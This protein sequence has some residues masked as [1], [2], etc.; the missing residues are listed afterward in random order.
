MD[1]NKKDNIPGWIIFLSFVTGFWPIGLCMMFMNWLGI[2]AELKKSFQQGAQQSRQNRYDQSRARTQAQAQRQTPPFAQDAPIYTG[3][4]RPGDQ[5][6]TQQQAWA[7][8]Q[9]PPKTAKKATQK[10]KSRFKTKSKA[11]AGILTGGGAAL[12]FSMLIPLVYEWSNY[13]FSF[14]GDWF[15]LVGFLCGGLYMLGTGIG[16]T[17]KQKRLR[18]YIGVI[19]TRNSVFLSD[20]ASAAGV[21]QKKVIDDLQDFLADGT[22]PM[23]YID[24]ASGRLVFTDQGF[25]HAAEPP[26][27]EAK[28]D[29]EAEKKAQAAQED[30]DNDMLREIKRVND[31][32]PD[33]EMSRK[34]DRIGEI[35][36]KILDYQ[37]RNPG[38]SGE[39]RQFLNYYLP[40]TLKILQA[41]AQL[42]AQGVEGE[43]ISAAKERIEGMMDKVVE[44]FE[45]QLDQL[46]RADAMD[47]ATDVEV[48]E[49]MLDKDGLGS[50]MTMG[51]V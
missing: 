10:V 40:T 45:K 33:P 39:L 6:R 44:G 4:A 9:V 18:L 29:P 11:L 23:G 5:Q 34:I 51:G 49:R 37:R 38:K 30:R 47:I 19:G 31:A 46:F 13:G 21:S 12:S 24:R 27:T 41:Y 2:P 7:Q 1:P 26:K 48:L 32:I 28:K 8:G 35:T 16:M 17:R 20:L 50:G 25:E 22:L 14:V 43:N 15:P 42:E 36:G 3:Q